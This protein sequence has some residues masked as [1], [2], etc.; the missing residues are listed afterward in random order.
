MM[1]PIPVLPVLA[2]LFGSYEECHNLKCKTHLKNALHITNA[3]S[4]T[5]KVKPF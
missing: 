1:V 4:L 2:V 3:T 5:F